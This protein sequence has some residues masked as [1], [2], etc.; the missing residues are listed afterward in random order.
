MPVD[1]GLVIPFGPQPGQESGYFTPIEQSLPR[2]G[3]RFRS[4]WMTD[5]FFWNDEP[6]YEAWTVLAYAAAR[7]PGVQVGP[8]VL[9]QSY[10]NPALL[11]KMGATLH[12][13]SGGRFIMGIGAG[14]K[15][16]EY[17]AYGYDYPRPGIRLE[18]LED[19]LE[20]MTRL[21]REPGKVTYTGTH[22]HIREAWCEPKPNP[23]I[24]LVVGGGGYKT[25]R[26]AA[27]FA[28]MWN[29]SDTPLIVYKERLTTLRQHCGELGRD[30]ASLRKSWFGRIA[31]GRTEAEAEAR[32]GKQWTR[33]NAFVGTPGQVAEQMAAFVD[34]GCDYFMVEILGLPDDDVIGMITE[35]IMPKLQ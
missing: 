11:A 30:W 27:R 20:I 32:G 8:M 6:T 5:H 16:D 34:V 29:V 15:E 13:L 12:A 1:F 2:L 24:P 21:W 7:F 33:A 22:Y 31:V 19:T 14:W 9:G 28:D 17:H 23:P 3:P 26:L 10:R 35:Q 25:M 18:Q 4:L